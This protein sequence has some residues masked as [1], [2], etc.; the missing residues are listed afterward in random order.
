MQ[1]VII[2]FWPFY[3]LFFELRLQNVQTYIK[4]D[5]ECCG[6]FHD[7]IYIKKGENLVQEIQNQRY[8]MY[9]ITK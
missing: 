5:K 1:H 6:D 2:D 4:H 8:Y 9:Y 3:C 7:N